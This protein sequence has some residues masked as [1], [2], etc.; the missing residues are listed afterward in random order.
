MHTHTHTHT[1]IHAHTHMHTHARTH[2]HA[3]TQTHTHM[4][5]YMLH[6]DNTVMIHFDGWGP[7]YNY[8]CPS[9]SVELHPAGWC[10]KHGW[11]LQPPHGEQLACWVQDLGLRPGYEALV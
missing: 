11:E 5:S 3:H 6:P 2:T 1:C 10:E 7:G 4:H 9:D 8:W